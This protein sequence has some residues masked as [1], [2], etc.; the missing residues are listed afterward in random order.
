MS[1][2]N[3]VECHLLLADQLNTYDVLISDDVVFTQAA[4][5]A[6]FVARPG[7]RKGVGTS[8]EEAATGGR[9]GTVKDPRDSLSPRAFP[10]RA[11]G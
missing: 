1:V 11:T 2:R 9:E 8:S 6:S 7:A 10:K 4:L 3:V 5:D